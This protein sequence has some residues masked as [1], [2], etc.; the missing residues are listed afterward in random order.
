M[1]CE[2]CGRETGADWKHLC[3]SCWKEQKREEE[4][5]NYLNAWRAGNIQNDLCDAEDSEVE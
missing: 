3:L 4:D 2:R 1:K 5:R